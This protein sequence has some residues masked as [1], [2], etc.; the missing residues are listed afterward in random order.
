ML[1]LAVGAGG[2]GGATQHSKAPA[3]PQ[4][5]AA[6]DSAT[7]AT[8]K[9]QRATHEAQRA[10]H[11]AQRA[12]RKAS[13]ANHK[14]TVASVTAGRATTS[15][16]QHGST[17]RLSPRTRRSTYVV[18]SRP[19]VIPAGALI[20]S[21][22]G[23]GNQTIGSVSEQRTIVIEWTADKAPIQVFTSKGFLLVD[24]RT[25]TGRIRLAR[26]DYQDLHVATRGAWTLQL[27]AQA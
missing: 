11:R 14:S 16:H 23:T 3:D 22:S 27:H 24:S 10:A 4:R 20:G 7:V 17:T 1:A 9:A 25:Q 15:N 5:T 13:N 19:P 2:C 6:T 21:F 12:T 26:G 18:A 8:H